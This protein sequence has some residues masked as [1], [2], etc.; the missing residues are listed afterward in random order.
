MTAPDEPP[1]PPWA[2]VLDALGVGLLLIGFS[3]AVTGGFREFTPFGR[4]SV[5]SWLRPVLLGLGLLV[6]RHWRW[7]RP[8]IP[9][10]A[11]AG[12]ERLRASESARIVWPIFVSTR[13]GVL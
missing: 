5:T 2:R 10:R 4:I 6:V 8:S 11:L 1:L 13:I 7:R 9:S 12:I 3:V